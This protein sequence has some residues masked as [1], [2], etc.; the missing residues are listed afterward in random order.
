MSEDTVN[1]ED[2]S[3]FER[4]VDDVR[5]LLKDSDAGITDLTKKFEKIDEILIE[6]PETAMKFLDE[7]Y[8][9]LKELY[10]NV[11]KKYEDA[12]SKYNKI[13]NSGIDIIEK[14]IDDIRKKKNELLDIGFKIDEYIKN[15]ELTEKLL[16][17]RQKEVLL[18]NS[19]EDS[20]SSA[21]LITSKIKNVDSKANLLGYEYAE[22]SGKL[23]GLNNMLLLISNSVT[24]RKP[25]QI[26]SL[27][28]RKHLHGLPI[29]R[30]NNKEFEHY[31]R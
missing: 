5:K 14:H 16:D 23:Y 20:Y 28:S 8:V 31:I 10:D 2:I 7:I 25:D 15:F 17:M 30:E 12:K 24:S 3:E 9:K 1:Q 18:F 22:F 11:S 29:G 27:E 4:I 19:I 26:R 13:R 6:F 21:M